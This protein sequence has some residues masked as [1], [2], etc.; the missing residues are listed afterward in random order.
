MIIKL[1]GTF[2]SESNIYE[3]GAYVFYGTDSLGIRM[4][5]PFEAYK[6]LSSDRNYGFMPSSIGLLTDAGSRNLNLMSIA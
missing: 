1:R 3:G 6:S 2:L 4:W 5:E